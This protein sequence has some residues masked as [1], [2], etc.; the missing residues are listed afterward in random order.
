ML[1]SQTMKQHR[2]QYQVH[3][4]GNIAKHVSWFL[5]VLLVLA[6]SGC[7]ENTAEDANQGSNQCTENELGAGAVPEALYWP[8]DIP[9]H[10]QEISF[11]ALV[12]SADRMRLQIFDRDGN[13]QREFQAEVGQIQQVRN[14]RAAD[15][16]ES[17][18]L[19]S[20]IAQQLV[21]VGRSEILECTND[22]DSY[23][24]EAVKDGFVDRQTLNSLF[25][26][27]GE[28][29]FNTCEFIVAESAERTLISVDGATYLVFTVSGQ[30]F[31]GEM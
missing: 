1:N 24:A 18:R 5:C 30:F 22:R 6:F 15:F 21:D 16:N 25:F 27:A 28:G 12:F 13:C 17:A 2:Q 29:G 11:L 14:W 3:R 26:R 4:A 31:S 19:G 10:E 7:E 23:Q 20:A 9:R 8:P